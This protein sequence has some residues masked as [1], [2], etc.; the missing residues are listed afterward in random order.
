LLSALRAHTKAP[1][2]TDLLWKTLRALKRPGRARTVLDGTLVGHDAVR[3]AV[4]VRRP[5]LVLAGG[6]RR[7]VDIAALPVPA[8]PR[9]ADGRLAVDAGLHGV[10]ARRVGGVELGA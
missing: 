4:D 3:A 5:A 2:K 10:A 7:V 6:V 9:R 1:S 8:H